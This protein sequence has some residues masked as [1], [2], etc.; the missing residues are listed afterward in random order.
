MSSFPVR[1]GRL[2]S[3]VLVTAV[4]LTVAQW[5]VPV[6][7]AAQVSSASS[8]VSAVEPKAP[9]VASDVRSAQLTAR[10]RGQRVEVESLR[11]E[12]SSTWV[13]QDGTFTTEQH[14]GPIRFRG[15]DGAWVDVDLS[16]AANPD[17]S[18]GPRGHAGGLRLKGASATASGTA[19]SATETDVVSVS[20]PGKTSREVVLGWP[21]KVGK[22]VLVGEK[23][24]YGEVQPGVDLVVES[25]RSGFEQLLVVKSAAALAALAGAAT[26]GVVSWSLPVKTKGLTARAETDGSVSFVDAKDVVVSRFEAPMAWDAKVDPRSGDP[27]STS[28]VKVSVAQAGKGRAVLTLTPDQGWLADPARVF[29]ITVDPTYSSLTVYPSYDAFVQNGYSTDLSASTELRAGTFDG[30]TTVARSFLNFP[31]AAFK[32]TQIQS[33]SFSVVENY[34]FSC[35]ARGLNVKGAALAS[36]ATRWTAQPVINSTISGSITAAA[37]YSAACPNK[38]LSIPITSLVASWAAGTAAT[39]TLALIAASETDSYGWKKFASSET[40]YDPALIITY[41]RYPNTP[42]TPTHTPGTSS[43]TGVTGWTNSLT[44]TLRATVTDPDGGMVQGLFSV[45]LNGTGAPII[46]KAYG[47]SVSSGGTSVYTVPAGKLVSGSYYVVRVY[48]Y[49]GALTSAAWSTDYDRFTVDTVAP[50]A[51]PTVS[52]ATFPEGAWSDAVDGAKKAHFDIT[53]GTSDSTTLQ[54]YLGGSAAWGNTAAVTGTTPTIDA[55]IDLTSVGFGEH[56]LYARSLDLAGNASPT[57]TYAFFYGTGV[58]LAQPLDNQVTARRLPLQLT[59]DPALVTSLGSPSFEYRRGDADTVWHQ[60]PLGPQGDVTTPA[61]AA[62]TDWPAQADSTTMYYWD[63]ATTLGGIGGVIEVRAK[64]STGAPAT[65]AVTTTVDIDDGQAA[66]GPA[67]PGSVNL[68]TGA[69]SL[70]ASDANWFGVGIGRSYGSRSLTAGTS[71]GQ[72][73]AFGPQWASGATGGDSSYTMVRKTSETSLDVLA[74]GDLTSFT[75]KDGTSGTT[76][77]WVPQPGAEDLQLVGDPTGT[78]DSVFTLTTTDRTVVTFKKPDGGPAGTWPVYETTSSGDD[79]AARYASEAVAGKLR[80]SVIA[81]PNPGLTPTQLDAC[82]TIPVPPAGP[83]RGCRVLAL[84]WGDVTTDTGTQPRVSGIDA[85]AWDPATSAMTKTTL[86]GFGYD[87]Q[88]WLTSATDTITNLVTGYGYDSTGLLTSLTPAH[89]AS[90]PTARL[91]WTFGYAAAGVTAGPVWDRTTPTSGGRLVAVSRATLA[92]GSLSATN[93]TA[94]TAFVYGVPVT[95]AGHGPADVAA[96]NT[97]SWGQVDPALEGTAVFAADAGSQPG[98][99]TDF[100]A[101]DDATTRS[102]AAAAVTYVDVNGREV[103]HYARDG[104]LDATSYDIDGNQVFALNAGNRAIATGEAPGA[105]DLGLAGQDSAVIGQQLATITGYQGGTI[106]TAGDEPAQRPA[107]TAGPLHTVVTSA[108]DLAQERAVTRDTYDQGR[109]ATIA[110]STVPPAA[111]VATSTVTGGVVYGADPATAVLDDQ[112]TATTTYDWALGQSLAETVDPSTAAGDEITTTTGY[113]TEGRVISATMP[114]GT[115]AGTTLTSYYDT[116]TA[117]PCTGHPEWGGMVCTKAAQG[118]IAS[119]ANPQLVSTTVT[120]TRTGAPDVVVET[121]NGINRTTTTTYDSAERPATIAVTATTTTG[122]ATTAL[123]AVVATRTLTYDPDT[124]DTTTVSATIGGATQSIATTTDALGRSVSVTDGTG[125]AGNTQYDALDRVIQVTQTDTANTLPGGAHRSFAATS[126]YDPNTGRLSSSTDDQAG[127][128]TLGYDT[129]GGLTSQAVTTGAGTLTMTQAGDPTGTPTS[130]QWK[131]AGAT[132]PLTTEQVTANIHGQWIDHSTTAGT[133]RRYTY[134]RASRLTKVTNLD[135]SAACTARSYSYTTNSDRLGEAATAPVPAGATSA[136]NPTGCTTPASPAATHTFDSADRLTDPGYTYDAFGRTTRLPLGGATGTAL[137][138]Q[139]MRVAYNVNDL[140]AT[141]QVYAN[142]TDADAGQNPTATQTYTLDVTGQRLQTFTS[143]GPDPDTGLPVTTTKTNRFAS[144]SDSPEWIDEGTTGPA[145]GTLTRNITGPAGHLLATTTNPVAGGAGTLNWQLTSLHGDIAATL[146]D[147]TT[148]ALRA[149]PL[150]D[151]FGVPDPTDTAIHGV[152]N[153]YGWL[154]GQQRSTEAPA[155]VYL[156]GVR[157]YN[158]TTGRFLSTDPVVGGN[159][160]AYTYP[161]DPINTFDLG[162]KYLGF[163]LIDKVQWTHGSSGWTLHV[164]PTL[165]ARLFAPA[166]LSARAGWK[167]VKQ[168]AGR[169]WGETSMW[170]QYL[171]H[172]QFVNF[173]APRRASWNLDQW[174]P[175]VGYYRTVRANCNPS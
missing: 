7:E 119:G 81:A 154:G 67:G 121:A 125:L 104:A 161:L 50:V 113:D 167:E 63:A 108:G 64:F 151:E 53:A 29:P 51:A 139:V 175:N 32:G 43:K 73:G 140:V 120:Y 128:M 142:A 101:G 127:T 30:G 56:V 66:S 59:V 168:K 162:G 136:T 105:D 88:G 54:W 124:G 98:S 138:G 158:P 42:G 70:S 58:A 74:A 166:Y 86:A 15:K 37:G 78:A 115:A 102:W 94:T 84:T 46:N 160:N 72:A 164:F 77:S 133:V 135:L 111:D 52:S 153:R 79:N 107:Y 132:D 114:G 31:T 2:L 92:P 16:L 122:A 36:T 19:A 41:N 48:G 143:T 55:G 149:V 49:D 116:A 22:P 1:G 83:A 172:V 126:T 4:A 40:A 5:D 24:T 69:L 23:A 169:F 47:S 21:G 141:Q 131:L 76:A 159:A 35:T 96:T 9:L 12:S 6:A 118:P 20:E 38:R 91:P 75:L 110:G 80:L 82:A 18:A 174:R 13:N 99:N 170:N 147:D 27:V 17:G 57:R 8:I 165:A 89:A 26:G 157:L 134:D 150:A 93:G 148:Q 90:A 97:A 152:D 61:G 28:P 44:P 95:K 85:W 60:L 100:W 68:T 106:T 33:A 171:C 123:G 156:M 45:Y 11:E 65:L 144:G 3:A 39:A 87:A 146:P 25:R 109:P 145:A 155:G 112:R 130:R 34:S 129:D 71:D 10:V 137:T 173:R 163:R 14:G 62:V 117:A 103:N